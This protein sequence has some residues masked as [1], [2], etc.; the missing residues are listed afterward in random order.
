[1]GE[2]PKKPPEEEEVEARRLGKE[3]GR[4]TRIYCI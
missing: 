4:G 2:T 1:L 3:G